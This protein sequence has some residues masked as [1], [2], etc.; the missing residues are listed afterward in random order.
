MVSAGNNYRKHTS[1]FFYAPGAHHPLPIR[2]KFYDIFTS[3]F[4]E[5]AS[6]GKVFLIGDT[7]A[8]LGSALNDK[9]LNGQF[10]SNPNK[11]LFMQFLVYSGLTIL[12][13]KYCHGVPTYEIPK[14]SVQL[15]ICA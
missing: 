13:K 2:R 5:F 3:K 15:L 9:N 1:L 11:Q 14:K 4:A 8:R 6:L 7:N 12:N 10:V